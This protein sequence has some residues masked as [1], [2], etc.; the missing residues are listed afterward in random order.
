MYSH[1][2]SVCA[3]GVTP[4]RVFSPQSGYSGYCSIL[5]QSPHTPCRP[6]RA[7][8]QGAGVSAEQQ[9]RAG[10]AVPVVA[11]A[12]IVNPPTCGSVNY[13]CSFSS[14]LDTHTGPLQIEVP[15]I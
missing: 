6:L 15:L 10:A 5:T 1:P 7:F 2:A 11:T 8:K 12:N 14:P 3:A 9:V 13:T 4:F